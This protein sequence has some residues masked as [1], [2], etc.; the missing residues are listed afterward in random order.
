MGL[1][2]RSYLFHSGNRISLCSKLIFSER[3]LDHDDG[4]AERRLDV[5]RCHKRDSPSNL[6][7]SELATFLWN[8]RIS[9]RTRKQYSIR[10]PTIARTVRLPKNHGE[11]RLK[12]MIPLAPNHGYEYGTYQL[13]GKPETDKN[14][15][16]FGEGAVA[17]NLDLRPTRNDDQLDSFGR[18]VVREAIET[19]EPEI[20][21]DTARGEFLKGFLAAT[22]ERPIQF[23]DRSGRLG[24]FSSED[25]RLANEMM[26]GP[27]ELRTVSNHSTGKSRL[28]FNRP[29]DSRFAVVLDEL[30]TKK[31]EEPVDFPIVGASN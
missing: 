22:K 1:V 30:S 10:K 6:V 19:K 26:Q 20:R 5:R 14:D 7:S 28:I 9:L 23:P 24:I 29:G 25:M 15:L 17:S 3:K 4:Q 27:F 13:E 11:Q 12:P 18:S 16:S 31:R 2:S 21:V 8:L